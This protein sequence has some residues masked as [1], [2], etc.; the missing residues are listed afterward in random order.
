MLHRARGTGTDICR[1][2]L[3]IKPIRAARP[4]ARRSIAK[5]SPGIIRRIRETRL[6]AMKDFKKKAD[7]TEVFTG[8]GTMKG[9]AS[10]DSVQPSLRAAGMEV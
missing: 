6:I 1:P 3:R 5:H 7:R 8:T 4:S 9:I 2:R 10:Q